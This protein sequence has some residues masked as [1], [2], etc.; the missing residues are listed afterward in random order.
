MYGWYKREML[1]S[2]HAAGP[3]GG[4]RRAIAGHKAVGDLCGLVGLQAYWGEEGWLYLKHIF[5][6][7]SRGSG[8]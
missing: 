6:L 4:E 7:S 1:D 5:A 3:H 2:R 8:G